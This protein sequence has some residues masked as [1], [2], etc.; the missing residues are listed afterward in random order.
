MSAQRE[1][2]V[3]CQPDS[4]NLGATC[5]SHCPF[6]V[7]NFLQGICLLFMKEEVK[8]RGRR[9]D[10]RCCHSHRQNQIRSLHVDCNQKRQWPL[11]RKKKNLLSR[12][13]LKV[14]DFMFSFQCRT[15]A[16]YIDYT[17]AVCK[18]CHYLG[19]CGEPLP[20]PGLGSGRVDKTCFLL[21]MVTPDEI[22]RK[23]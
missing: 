17:F 11:S 6:A 13:C 4:K 16:D 18:T 19:G 14:C 3:L 8:A 20:S 2:S 23:D 22:T 12:G 5:Q 1:I 21:A 10:S 7:Q 9:P 15:I